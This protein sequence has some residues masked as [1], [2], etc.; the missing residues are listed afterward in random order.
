MRVHTGPP[1]SIDSVAPGAP[2]ELRSIVRTAM[3]RDPRSRFQSMEELAR[4]LAAF[5][6]GRGGAVAAE[7]PSP[8]TR[9]SAATLALVAGIAAA[10][11]ATLGYVLGA[12]T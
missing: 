3:A 12:A 1:A 11:A 10:V 8:R 5:L 7:P 6:E 9:P 4:E 2:A